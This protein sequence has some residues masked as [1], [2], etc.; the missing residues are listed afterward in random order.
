VISSSLIDVLLAFRKRTWLLLPHLC[1]L[2]V[3]LLRLANHVSVRPRY[4][5][6]VVLLLL[7]HVFEHVCRV[8]GAV[9]IGLN[10]LKSFLL[11]LFFL[12]FIELFDISSFLLL[13]SC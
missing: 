12:A 2:F 5:I 13:L 9:Q 4:A 1:H 8:L 3:D 10:L 6:V 11:S 7:L